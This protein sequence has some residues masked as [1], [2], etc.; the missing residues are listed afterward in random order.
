[1]Q[2]T[3]HKPSVCCDFADFRDCLKN[4]STRYFFFTV[5]RVDSEGARKYQ[6]VHCCSVKDKPV[7]IPATNTES[8]K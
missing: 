5:K 6:F 3:L 8:Q 4:V 2:L 7:A 1:M